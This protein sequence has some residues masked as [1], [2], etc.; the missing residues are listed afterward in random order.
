MTT[1]ATP[2]FEVT[3]HDCG[4][5]HPAEPHHQGRFGEG[6]VYAVVCGEFIEFYTQEVVREVAQRCDDC[7]GLTRQAFD[8]TP[9]YRSCRRCGHVFP[10]RA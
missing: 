8:T 3:C 1:P 4:Q 7:G 2:K 6:Q 10:A 5:V 9:D